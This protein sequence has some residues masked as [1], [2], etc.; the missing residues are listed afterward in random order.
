MVLAQLA[1]TAA[2]TRP[3]HAPVT[4]VAAQAWEGTQDY[5]LNLFAGSLGEASSTSL[6]GG[7]R[8]PV[9]EI[10]L[11][12]YPKSVGLIGIAV[13]GGAALGVVVGLLAAAAR[14]RRAR[15]ALLA[16]SILAIS[17]PSFLIAI[18]LVLYGA[19]LNARTGVRL[20]PT[21]GFGWDD[22]LIVPA[23][24]LG[25]RPFAQIANV[26]FVALTEVLARDY[27]RTARAKGLLESTVLVRHALRNSAVPILGAISVGISIGLASL[28]AVEAIFEWQ[29]V[30]F[31]LTLSIRRFDAA[32]AGTLLGALAVTLAIARMALDALADRLAVRGQATT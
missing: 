29:G 12:A 7:D 2:R 1:L 4:E 32:T 5:F 6:L 27:V 17:T 31:L 19:E 3:A 8:R 25:A 10:L 26:S 24:A 14:T 13:G 16:T 20:W 11:D 23:L 18:L 21:F 30:G 9:G 28:P 22:H 15:G